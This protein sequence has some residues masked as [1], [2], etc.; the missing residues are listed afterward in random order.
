[1]DDP[2]E[3][4]GRGLHVLLARLFDGPGNRQGEEHEAASTTRAVLLFSLAAT[5]AYIAFYVIRDAAGL[6]SAT[7][8]DG[9]FALTYIVCLVLLRRGRA[10]GAAILGLGATIP[11]ILV[12][13]SL[14]GSQVGMHVFMIAMGPAVF[15]VFTDAQSAFRWLFALSA[16]FVFVYCQFALEP[17][18]AALSV[19]PETARLI[20]SVNAGAAGLLVA[21]LAAV[22][23]SRRRV[24]AADAK[25]ATNRAQ[26][27]ANTDPLTGLA[28]RRPV[29]DELERISAEGEYCVVVADLDAFKEMNDSFGHLCGDHVLAGVGQELLRHIRQFD[30]V[31][32]WG[33][34]EFIFVLP[35]TDIADAVSFA[36]RLRSAIEE[37]SFE[38]S[39]H[40]HR[41]TASFGV[42]DGTDDGMAHRVVRRA[43]DAMYDAKEAG[44]NRVRMRPLSEVSLQPPTIEMPV[45]HRRRSGPRR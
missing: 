16:A 3:V 5:L 10:L 13:T 18:S 11:Q 36:E 9:A 45:A 21:L 2:D 28:N 23:H 17:T 8:T 1:M 19:S 6:R 29:M 4:E 35:R 34:E 7:L 24:S 32:R 31:G 15:M 37:C 20:F 33:G 30:T 25:R 39:S 44:R 43:D 12:C 26:F 40:T 14:L 27:L 38:C 42:A 22:E 41:V